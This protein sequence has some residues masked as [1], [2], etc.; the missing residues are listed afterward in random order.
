MI[1]F[2][3]DKQSFMPILGAP[4]NEFMPLPGLRKSTACYASLLNQPF[5]EDPIFSGE[6]TIT[7]SSPVILDPGTWWLSVVVDLGFDGGQWYWSSRTVQTGFAAVWQNPGDGFLTGCT[8]WTA[9]QD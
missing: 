5:T 2:C 9:K 4:S 3:Y 6:L 1:L 7:L 8:T